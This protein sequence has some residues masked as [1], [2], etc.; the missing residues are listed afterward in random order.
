[1]IFDVTFAFFAASLF[2][3]SAAELERVGD[4]DRLLGDDQAYPRGYPV[5]HA[6]V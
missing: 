5:L 2:L 6:S 3:L 1:M 4:F